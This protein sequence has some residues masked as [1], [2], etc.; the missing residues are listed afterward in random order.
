VEIDRT[1]WNPQLSKLSQRPT[2]RLF[3]LSGQGWVIGLTTNMK[4]VHSAQQWFSG[5]N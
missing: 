2:P 5:L 3:P 1:G 4:L